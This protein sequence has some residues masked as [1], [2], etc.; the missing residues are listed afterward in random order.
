GLDRITDFSRAE[1][2]RIQLDPGVTYSTAQVGAD[3]VVTLGGGGQV[4]LAGVQLSTLTD[5]WIFGA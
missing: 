1:G 3:T 4:V 5:G 2:D